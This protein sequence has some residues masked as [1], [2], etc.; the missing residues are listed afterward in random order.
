MHAL[1][2]GRVRRA[3]DAFAFVSEWQQQRY[4]EVYRTDRGRSSVLRNAVGPAFTNLFPD[5]QILAQKARPP[6]LAYTSTPFRGLEVL[7]DVFPRIRAAV[8]DVILRVYS[9]M[10][11]YQMSAER[12]GSRYG[13]LY[14]KC[15][16]TEGVEYV[17]SLPQ[18]E[19]AKELIRVSI[20]AYPNN[21]AETS[22]IAV[23]EAMA[24]G[25]HVITSDL[26]ALPETTADFGTLIPV[27]DDWSRYRDLFTEATV[28]ELLLLNRPMSEAEGQLARQVKRIN[29]ECT[30]RRR[31]LE[32]Q[33]FLAS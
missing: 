24:A 27:D 16:A 15:R 8:P 33:T 29:E 7:L 21:F 30:W 14:E 12:D 9:S 11:V 3:F 23:M 31:A 1:E 5:S 18:P 4:E 25:C 17:G 32:W 6:L 20:L 26:A 19:L 13:R 22:C 10:Q 28:A 2:D